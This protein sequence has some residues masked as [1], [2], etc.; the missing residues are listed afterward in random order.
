MLRR[1]VVCL[2]HRRGMAGIVAKRGASALRKSGS[3][4][5]VCGRR[6]P[7]FFVLLEMRHWKL[8]CIKIMIILRNFALIIHKFH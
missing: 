8:R 3:V 6:A 4:I 7:A 1:A 2:Y 5:A